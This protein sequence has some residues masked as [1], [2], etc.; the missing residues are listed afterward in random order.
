MT[1]D[2][3]NEALDALETMV[4][5]YTPYYVDGFHDHEFMTAG[6]QAVEA[7]DKYRP[8]RWRLVPRGVDRRPQLPLGHDPARASAGCPAAVELLGLTGSDPLR[9]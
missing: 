7:L 1:D 4:E 9:G 3:L 2:P 5:R 8:M 6:E